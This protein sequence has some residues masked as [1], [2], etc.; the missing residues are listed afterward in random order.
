MADP[1]PTRGG[2]GW[3][4][5][6]GE[7]AFAISSHGSKG[8][9]R[10]ADQEFSGLLVDVEWLDGDALARIVDLAK[11]GLPVILPRTPKPP[12]KRPRSDYEALLKSL[13]AFPNVYGEIADAGL[14]PLVAGDDLPSFWAR[15]TRESLFLFFSHPMA[16]AVR[17][18][19]RYGQSLCLD[20]V[21]RPITVDFSGEL[22]PIR[23]VF[24]PYQSLLVRLS[25]TAGVQFVDIR[26]QPPEPVCSTH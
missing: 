24:E 26:Y 5:H 19:M 3:R 7:K 21:V 4:G 18:P 6:S 12:G 10:I 1:S 8:R 14:A 25:R 16:R 22:H 9:L 23:L 15:R 11:A 17:Y 13:L 20:R 2:G